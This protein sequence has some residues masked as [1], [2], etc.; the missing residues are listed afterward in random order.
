LLFSIAKADFRPEGVDPYEVL[1]LQR[2]GD[3][4]AATLK[5]AYRQAA[6]RWHPDKVPEGERQEAEQKFIGIAWAYEVLSDPSRRAA[7]DEPPGR[8][9]SAE[10]GA[11]RPD[12]SG[13]A[14]EFSMKSAA[15]VFR[16]VFGDTSDEYSDLI[17]HLMASS[18]TGDR[19]QWEEHAQAIRR[20]LRSKGANGDFDVETKSSDGSSHIRSKQTSTSDGKGTVTKKTVTE[21]TH[22]SKTV[23]GAAALGG[24]P[25]VEPHQ[26][27]AALEAIKSHQAAHEAS[28]REAEEKHKAAVEAMRAH[29]GRQLPNPKAEL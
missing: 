3:L 7:Y 24:Q 16:D 25:P 8:S 15:K 27:A 10:G 1:G 14:R 23:N 11:P 17:R 19:K 13:E 5:K 2:G 26:I 9:G 20:S 29:M 4:S 12:S 6:L 22:T 21:S 28:V 18:S